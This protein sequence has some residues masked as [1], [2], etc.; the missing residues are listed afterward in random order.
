M[1]SISFAEGDTGKTNSF[2]LQ[3]QGTTKRMIALKWVS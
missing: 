3:I 1:N 2:L